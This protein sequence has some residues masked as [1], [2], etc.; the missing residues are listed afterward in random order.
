MLVGEVFAESSFVP[1]F[2][3]SLFDDISKPLAIQQTF[4]ES[5]KLAG[6]YHGK[7]SFISCPMHGAE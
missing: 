7:G 4:M 2:G 6:K 3:G 5:E 1:G